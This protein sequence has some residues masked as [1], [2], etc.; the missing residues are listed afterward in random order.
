[1]AKRRAAWFGFLLMMCGFLSSA[2]FAADG[3]VR[4][5]GNV[6]RLK[7]AYRFERS[8]WIYVHLEGS[9]A[10]I[11]YQHG[12]LLAPEIA[13]GFN[14]VK[15]RDT[16]RTKRDWD[17]YRNVAKTILWPKIDAEYQQELQGIADGLKAHGVNM[18]VWDVVALN[19]ME[20]VP[21]YYVPWL[22]KQEKRTDAPKLTAPGNCSAFVAT[23]SMTKDHTPVIAHSNWSDFPTGSRWTIVF[24]IVPTHGYH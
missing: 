22:D 19:A 4:E 14:T 5:T 11:G 7:P 13:D 1:M 8:K 15:F 12:Y 3:Q 17:F 6:V 9:P 10:D 16:H 21:D 20:E 18:D 24:D 2:T 23:G